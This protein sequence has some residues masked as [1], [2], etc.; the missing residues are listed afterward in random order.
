MGIKLEDEVGYWFPA[1][2]QQEAADSY[3]RHYVRLA[4][5]L[6]FPLPGASGGAGTRSG[7][8]ANGPSSSP[9]STRSRCS[10]A[11]MPSGCRPTRCSRMCTVR[12]RLRSWP[13]SARPSTSAT[14][15]PTWPQA[16]TAGALASRRADRLVQPGR[17]A[18]VGRR[19]RPRLTA[20]VS[21]VVCR[22]PGRSAG[23]AAPMTTDILALADRLWRGEVAHQR[24]P[25]GRPSRRPGRD[26][27]GRRV[28]ARVR[29]RDGDQDGGRPGAGRHRQRLRGAGD[30]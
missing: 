13:G 23:G 7:R 5:T 24:V 1:D 3:R 16:E 18:R 15:R 14:P 30:P 20:R 29:Q 19:G 17:P 12:R 4:P 9:P 25:P 26:L 10:R 8:R 2:G 28:R 21:V 6:T 11:W 27:R 22:L